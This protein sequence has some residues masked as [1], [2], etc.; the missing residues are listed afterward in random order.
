IVGDFQAAAARHVLRHDLR[1]ARY[2][3]AEVTRE[4]SSVSI[5]PTAYA[6]ADQ[7]LN[8]LALVE[9]GNRLGSGRTGCYGE[10][11]RCCGCQRG[12][13]SRYGHVMPPVVFLIRAAGILCSRTRT[14][15]VSSIIAPEGMAEL[16]IPAHPAPP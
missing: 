14:A 1:L 10:C 7:E 6:I 16:D 9:I 4:Q 3:I 11:K 8:R 13:F 2:V 12:E 15:G 5:V